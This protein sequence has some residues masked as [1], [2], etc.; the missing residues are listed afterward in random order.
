MYMT[1]NYVAHKMLH[2]AAKSC[3]V[4]PPAACDCTWTGCLTDGMPPLGLWR[5]AGEIH[6]DKAQL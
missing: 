2:V 1:L 5:S 6:N 3:T 4:L